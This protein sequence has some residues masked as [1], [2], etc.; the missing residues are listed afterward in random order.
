MASSPGNGF[1]LLIADSG[2][3]VVREFF[4]G[5]LSVLAGN[6]LAGYVDGGT[7]SAEFNNPT[8]LIG[9]VGVWVQSFCVSGCPCSSV[10]CLVSV[11]HYYTTLYVDDARNYVVRKI[12]AGS[13]PGGTG[14]CNSAIANTVSTVAGNH[15]QGYVDGSSSS[16]Q[17]ATLGGVAGAAWPPSSS[18]PFYLA[19]AQ[20][21]A[22]RS[23]DGANVST[24]A[25][26]GSHGLVN[27]YRTSASFGA[28]IKMTSDANGNMYVTDADNFVI[29]K[30][31]TTG[32]VTTF[33]GTGQNG[34]V[35]GPAAQAKFRHPTGI[36]F[37]PA[38]GYVYVANT[39]NNAIRRIDS[40]GNVSTYA[41]T[42]VAGLTNGSLSQ[43]QFF[44]P[45]DLLIFNGFMYVSDTNNNVIRRIDMTNQIVST[46]IS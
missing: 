4:N 11:P 36:V 14:A 2:N 1:H 13:P 28:P 40:A 23:W 41:G 37:N 46:Y 32:N 31:D 33:A 22:I 18:A 17:F 44:A 12:C 25:G 8:G 26:N 45:T 9:G 21:N 6:G 43:A 29:R 3:N 19:D 27:A 5:T 34:F 20:N 30:I 10:Y 35:D 7:G 38:D 15:T 42:G 39:Q 24:F 16:A